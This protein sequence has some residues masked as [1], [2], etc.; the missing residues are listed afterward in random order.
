[1]NQEK[2]IIFTDLKDFTYKNTL[3]TDTQVAEILRVFDNIIREAAKKY[4]VSVIK[5]IGDAYFAVSETAEA[6]YLF[7]K[8][9]LEK[10]QENDAQH[11]I[12]IKKIS[13]RVTLS[14]GNISRNTALELEDY[15]GEAINLGAR[16]MDMTPEGKIFCTEAVKQELSKEVFSEYL[17]KFSFHGILTEVPLYSLTSLS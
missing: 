4:E 3:L 17:G 7:S 6:A 10:A 16:I 5:S 14:Y 8:Y 15:F 9:I 2:Y 12:N 11:K 13:L 1:M